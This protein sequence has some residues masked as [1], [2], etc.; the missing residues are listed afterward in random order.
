MSNLWWLIPAAIVIWGSCGFLGAEIAGRKGGDRK[1]WFL[2]GVVGGIPGVVRAWHWGGRDEPGRLNGRFRRNWA[3][4]RYATRVWM[5]YGAVFRAIAAIYVVL[6]LPVGLQLFGVV[7]F[8]T[9]ALVCF[10]QGV[11]RR[12]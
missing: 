4:G 6:P 2:H 9:V 10:V 8:G 11:R 12:R 5:A 3:V 1:R 7:L